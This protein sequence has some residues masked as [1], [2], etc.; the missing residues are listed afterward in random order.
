M[1]FKEKVNTIKYGHCKVIKELINQEYITI[2]YI[3]QNTL[4]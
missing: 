1:E 3:S 2:I 4:S